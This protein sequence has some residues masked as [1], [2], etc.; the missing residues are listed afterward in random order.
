MDLE[1]VDK[2]RIGVVMGVGIGG[3]RT[4]EDEV[5]NWEVKGPTMG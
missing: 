3:M 2:N 1:A 4:F 5:Y